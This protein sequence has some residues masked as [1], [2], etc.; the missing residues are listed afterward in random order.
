M[1]NE[2]G[3]CTEL[4]VDVH[5][6]AYLSVTQL[7][8]R[9]WRIG[10]MIQPRLADAEYWWVANGDITVSFNAGDSVTAIDIA[11]DGADASEPH[12]YIPSDIAKQLGYGPQT[13]A[14]VSEPLNEA[15]TYTGFDFTV[16][17]DVSPMVTL[18]LLNVHQSFNGRELHGA[19]EFRTIIPFGTDEQRRIVLGRPLQE[20]WCTDE[21]LEPGEAAEVYYTHD[22]HPLVG[23]G[24]PCAHDWCNGQGVVAETAGATP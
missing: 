11:A 9:R 17:P 19:S 15:M 10:T 3:L 13:N 21:P 16:D 22:V 2:H 6:D 4:L 12:L 18:G 7:S 24:L 5:A 1:N 14:S 8:E 20:V 23:A